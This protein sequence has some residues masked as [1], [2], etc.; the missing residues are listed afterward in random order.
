LSLLQDRRWKAKYDSDARN[1]VEDFFFPALE[2]A[3][4]YDRTTGYFSAAIL[5]LAARGIE[6]L[7]RN[8]GRMRLV[9][10]CTLDA[11]EAEA[12]ARGEDA[13]A[14]V[15]AKMKESPLTARSADEE[16]G[17]ELLSWMVA[18][19]FLEVRVAIP[20][21][22]GGK[23]CASTA[24][25]HEKTGV[26]EDKTGD[27]IA[28]SGSLNETAAGWTQN[29]E[30]FHVFTSWD[31][32]LKHIEAEEKSF[33]RLWADKADRCRVLDVPQ[34]MREDLL[35]FLPA[36]DELPHRLREIATVPA[37]IVTPESEPSADESRVPADEL[38]H[39]VWSI[40]RDGPALRG[41][42][43]RVG[44]ATSIVTPWP[45]QVRAFKRLYESWSPR[46]LIADEVGLGKTIEA[47]LVLRQAVLAGLARRILVLAPKAVLRQWQVELRD[48]FNLNWPIYDG[49]TLRWYQC[50]A[51]AGRDERKVSRDE[52]HK[53]PFALVSSQLMRRVD[54]ARELVE[55]AAPWDLIVLDEAHHARRKGGG[56]TKDKAPNQLLDL[57]QRLRVRTK[58][59]ILLTATPMQVHPVEVWDLLD[60]LGLPPAWSEASFL[61]FFVL[62]GQPSPSNDDLD[63]M[64][65]LFRAAEA[66]YGEIAADVV[67]RAA[68]GLGNLSRKKV[69]K[70]LRSG[71]KTDLKQLDGDQRRAAVR[72]T[73]AGT[74]VAR[75]ISRHTRELLR[76]YYQAGQITTRVADRDVRDEFIELTPDERAVYEAVEHYIA[77]T[78]DTASDAE[79]SAVGFV[80][81]VYRRRLASSFAALAATLERRFE[82]I[83]SGGLL[84]PEEDVADDESVDE[85]MDPDEAG[86]LAAQVLKLEEKDE[87]RGLLSA[88]RRLPGVDTKAKV[89]AAQ[90][91]EIQAAEYA[92]A[93]VF[94]QYSDTLDFLRE[95]L[96]NE[97]GLE[98]LC[99]SGRGGEVR[100]KSGEWKVVDRDEV[101][102]RFRDGT[103]QI[104]LCTDAAA[105]GLNFQFCGALV[106][107]DMPW[108]PMRVEQRIGRIDRL[109]QRHEKIRI[110]NLHYADTVETDVYVALRHRIGLF[111]KFV[112]KLQP[113]LATLPRSLSEAVLG[114]RD[115]SQR[116]GIVSDLEE[117]I[118]KQEQEGFDLDAITEADLREPS[119]PAALYDLD[120]LDELIRR[121]ELLP[122]GYEVQPL[123]HR[124]Y[125][126]LQ[127]GM[128]APLRVT[129]R[130]EFFEDHPGSAELWS[131][132]SPL[133]P[134]ASADPAV[135]SSLPTLSDAL[136]MPCG[137]PPTDSGSI[138]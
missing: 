63:F 51:T 136:S 83:D 23:P 94:T 45:H 71:A 100:E 19:G 9:V 90:L 13:R 20:C 7:L 126:V 107:Y 98:V 67:G 62:A 8:D 112:G 28:F 125:S 127:P 135:T 80:M 77:S 21:T 115:K 89:L 27:R 70:A 11:A 1:L 53:E 124:E 130:A 56:T 5:S 87:I 47:G 133:F 68:S 73:V 50:L 72:L 97:A 104:L 117:R 118:R 131:P 25:F 91:A 96:V 84:R 52:W 66:A 10:G 55:D 64:A 4:R 108:N 128:K 116:E 69:L 31:G 30:S 37:I 111:S 26:I 17:L 101:K 138:R 39:L 34:A 40:V 103:A 59:L 82:G 119:R 106:N 99:F 137:G 18:R 41:P 76:R 65:G 57:M 105:E 93:I 129:T 85:T 110:G 22:P 49:Q 60:L 132:G 2:C 134:P 58:G 12:I 32:G 113:I 36:N 81:T 61:R 42:G 78:Y 114:A 102:R 109:G 3:T 54:R 16:H 88:I 122:P 46:L 48:K 38:R 121:P 79:R 86:K 43:D 33:A 15:E 74:P 123:G 120:A 75:L 14:V 29:W 95:Y 92:K 44:E 35:R 6:Y 24:I